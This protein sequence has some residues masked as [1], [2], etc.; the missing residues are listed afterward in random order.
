[1]KSH[2]NCA[3]RLNGRM[4][5]YTQRHFSFAIFKIYTID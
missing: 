4:Q 1:M 5:A 2:N 3:I